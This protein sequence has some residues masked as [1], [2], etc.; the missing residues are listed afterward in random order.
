MSILHTYIP[1]RVIDDNGIADGASLA[2]Y[3]TG[4]LTPATIYADAD[5]TTPRANPVIIPSGA[6]VPDVYLD[7]NII[8]RRIVTYS[9]GSTTD[10]DPYEGVTD[11][12]LRANLAS[13]DKGATLINFEPYGNK[14]TVAGAD[15]IP[16]NVY[17]ATGDAGLRTARQLQAPADRGAHIGEQFSG[18]GIPLRPTGSGAN[19]PANADIGLNVSVIKDGTAVGEI[20]AVNAVVRQAGTESDACAFLADVAGWNGG[21]G[22]WGQFEG[23]T[24]HIDGGGTVL[25]DIRVQLGVIDTVNN[26]SFGI[27]AIADTGTINTGL[28]FNTI[29]GGGVFTN[30]ITANVLGRVAF[31]VDG[32]G[33]IYSNTGDLPS[34]QYSRQECVILE[35]QTADSVTGH[36]EFH[37]YTAGSSW[38][39]TEFRIRGDVEEIGAPATSPWMSFRGLTGDVSQITF[40]F[41]VGASGFD[42]VVIPVGGGVQVVP[43]PADPAGAL[44]GTIWFNETTNQ[45]K[46]MKNG[47]VIAVIA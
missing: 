39:S 46:V 31:N 40:G 5:L 37:R 8:Y 34:T 26:S 42:R 25:K 7:E 16:W 19:G 6:E 30:H 36:L 21:T 17:S 47:G 20:D 15:P 43:V 10:T 14:Y 28:L 23:T 9:D 35:T 41:G 1:N 33:Q 12:V 44:P 29:D 13:P 27:Y 32:E 45:L 18:L 3:L 24:K 38:K 2:F 4:T 11:N 22:F